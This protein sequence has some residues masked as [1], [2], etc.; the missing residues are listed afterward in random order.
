[1][2]NPF[3]KSPVSSQE[4]KNCLEEIINNLKR[5]IVNLDVE[6]RFQEREKLRAREADLVEIEKNIL[7]NK[8]VR[9]IFAR[10]LEVAQDEMKE[11][12]L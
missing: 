4:K 11:V 1:M 6:T 7:Q 12:K 10:K 2:D 3:K 5:S 9:D 8:R